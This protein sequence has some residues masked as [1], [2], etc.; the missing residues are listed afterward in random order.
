MNSKNNSNLSFEE[1]LSNEWASAPDIVELPF[2]NRPLWYLAALLFMI[3]AVIGFRVIFL[4]FGNNGKFYVARASANLNR[5]DYSSAPRGMVVDRNGITLATNKAVFAAT[6]DL[7][8]F[9]QGSDQEKTLDNIEKVLGIG[10]D[11]I[12]QA[13]KE[14]DSSQITD[15][16]VLTPALSQDQLIQLKTI[17]IPSVSIVPSYEREYPNGSAFS[18]VIG[19]TNLANPADI[20]QDSNL[21]SRDVVGRSGI[22]SYYDSVLRGT[23]SVTVTVKDAKG[24]VLGT[25]EKSPAKPGATLQLTIDQGLQEYFYQRMQ[26]GLRTLGRTAGGALAMNPQTGEILA[27][28]SFPGYDNNVLVSPAKTSE[29][30]DILTSSGRPLFNRIVSGQYN[31]GSTIKPLVAIAALKENIIDPLRQIFSP[32]YLELPNKLDPAH[33]LRFLDWRYQGNVNIYTAL[34]FSSDVYFY[35]VGGGAEGIAGLGI[36]KLHEWWDKFAFGERT[37]IDLAGEAKGFLPTP[38]W[39][40]K[41]LGTPWLLG[42]TFNV[43]IGQG[44]LLVTPL[45]LLNYISSIANGGTLYRPFLVESSSSRLAEDQ[46]KPSVLEDLSGLAPQIREIQKGMRQ[47]V[48]NHLGTAFTLHD[49]P[50]DIAAKT[51]SAQVKNNTQ[52]NAFFVGYTPVEALAKVGA[53]ASKQLAVLVLIENSKEGSLNAVPIARDVFNWYY[54][55]RLKNASSSQ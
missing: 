36:T 47:T 28:M 15:P 19:Y 50:I 45:Q 42:D 31:P 48:T 6:L 40:Q 41:V 24:K 16:I 23:P 2:S 4:N 10:R 12:L 39:K 30:M 33:P 3:G 53:P 9:L 5:V 14:R 13:V 38:D 27:L 35:I 17:V 18:S 51:G 29:K 32:G 25:E 55:N 46:T 54:E 26:E 11:E 8:G 21:T 44:D 34:A 20:Q 37:G 43:A 22:E 1:A 52:E 7:R 49:L